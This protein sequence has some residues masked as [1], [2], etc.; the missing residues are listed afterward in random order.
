MIILP[1]SD[2]TFSRQYFRFIEDILHAFSQVFN[3]G[4]FISQ[5]YNSKNTNWKTIQQQPQTT[6]KLSELNN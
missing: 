6:R 2:T 4:R 5:N 3:L 1:V